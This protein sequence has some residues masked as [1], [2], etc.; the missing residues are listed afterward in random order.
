MFRVRTEKLTKER[1]SIRFGAM[2]VTKSYNKLLFG[3]VHG[4]KASEFTRF[5]GHLAPR[6]RYYGGVVKTKRPEKKPETAS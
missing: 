5:P 2:D 4:L 6:H 1:V 3:D